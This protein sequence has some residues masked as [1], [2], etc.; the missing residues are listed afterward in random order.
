MGE[1]I[2]A[3]HSEGEL[4]YYNKMMHA[5]QLILALP[6]HVNNFGHVAFV[7]QTKKVNSLGHIPERLVGQM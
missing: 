5:R 3:S 6:R 2:L 1:V 4:K 7:C